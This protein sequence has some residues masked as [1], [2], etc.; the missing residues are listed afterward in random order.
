MLYSD[1]EYQQKGG[2][3]TTQYVESLMGKAVQLKGQEYINLHGIPADFWTNDEWSVMGLMRFHDDGILGSSKEIPVLGDGEPVKD[4]GFHLGL[5]KQVVHDTQGDR[6]QYCTSN[7]DTVCNKTFD[8]FSIFLSLFRN[9]C[10][11]S[12][13]MMLQE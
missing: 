11:V 7:H 1:L 10:L 3:N 5:I 9:C 13:P 6:T 8:A 4:K 2:R 12:I